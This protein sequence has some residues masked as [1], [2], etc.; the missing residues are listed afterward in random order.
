MSSTRSGVASVTQET[1]QNADSEAIAEMHGHTYEDDEPGDLEPSARL[2]F[3]PDGA[4]ADDEDDE[5]DDDVELETVEQVQQATKKARRTHSEAHKEIMDKSLV[6]LHVDLETA[7]E[8]V[9]VVQLSC[10]AHDLRTNELI[11]PESFNEYIKPPDNITARYWSQ[12]AIDITG[13][14]H[15]HPSI[16]EAPSVSA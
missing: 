12:K 16:R 14:H 10:V 4:L 11:G 8:A 6:L 1:D 9:G 15:N 2:Q 5:D 3:G 7:G 13:L